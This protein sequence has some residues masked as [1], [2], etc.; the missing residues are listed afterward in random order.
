MS[1]LWI[2]HRDPRARAALSRLAAAPHDALLGAPGDPVFA[3]APAPDAV[4]LGVA[5]PFE[6]EL[7]FVHQQAARL[8]ASAWIL[9]GERAELGHARPLF[10]AIDADWLAHPPEAAALRRRLRALA[11]RAGPLPLP[12]SERAL[13]DALAAR[14]ARWFGDLDLPALLR[15]LDPR[16]ADVPVLVRG[17]PGSGR[18]SLARYIHAFGGTRGGAFAQVACTPGLSLAELRDAVAAAAREALASAPAAICLLDVDRLDPRLQRELLDW[19]ELAPPPGLLRARKPRWLA[20]AGPGDGDEALDPALRQALAGLTLRIPPLRERAA[21]IPALVKDLA[22]RF[23]AAR[24]ERPRRFDEDALRV[25][26][27]HPWPG[28]LRE[29]ESVVVQTL[30]ASSSD[31]LT[32]AD[33]EQDGEPFAPVDAEAFGAVLLE[34]GPAEAA[35]ESLELPD[36]PV[37]RRERE[38]APLPPPAR[39]EPPAPGP[40]P[41]AA[42]PGLQPLAAALD[43]ELRN[44]LTGIQTFAELLPER[45]A[46]EEF[47]ARFAERTRADLRRIEG[48]LESLSRAAA[49]GAPAPE[50]VDVTGLLSELL[51][52]QRDAIRERRLLVLQELD[53]QRGEARVDPDQL[54]FALDALLGACFTLVPERGDVYLASKHHPSGLR[55]QPSLRVLIRFHGPERGSRS[56]LPDVSPLRNSL[57]FVLT[58]HVVR[59]NGGTFAINDN[60]GNETVVILELPA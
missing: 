23:C 11:R 13:R 56:E 51:E 3:S 28:N 44:P 33:L 26:G 37:P 49:L 8:R 43:H 30:A 16:L 42:G 34:D 10:D 53:A 59:A 38:P 35:V 41:A 55:G 15:A 29:L 47:R 31:P 24:A 7:E 27:E 52:A 18:A 17:E 57:G 1:R 46:D 36:E 6:A 4:L 32:P 14:I 39:E 19:I 48:T 22:A 45:W 20:T 54:R 25:L 50:P 40:T 21:S 5:A 60:E 58:E 12:L 2:V 9:I